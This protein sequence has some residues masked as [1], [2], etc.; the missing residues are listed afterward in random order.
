M[1]TKLGVANSWLCQRASAFLLAL[2]T[3]ITV[4]SPAFGQSVKTI[5]LEKA[6]L[7]LEKARNDYHMGQ[8][9]VERASLAKS[10]VDQLEIA[11]R[12]ALLDYQEKLVES[13]LLTSGIAV[14][15]AVRQE[16]AA[17]ERIVRLELYNSLS[18]EQYLVG[19]DTELV[20]IPLLAKGLRAVTVSLLRDNTI[21]GLPY[22]LVIDEWPPRQTKVLTFTMLED[23][24][25]VTIRLTYQ[26]VST[27]R[28]VRLQ[29]E[30]S[31]EA[32][33]LACTHPFQ[34]ADLG[35]VTSFGLTL[36]RP[37]TTQ[38]SYRLQVMGLPQT[39]GTE[40]VDPTS[41]AR[42][43]SLNFG[44]AVTSQQV[45]LLVTLPTRPDSVVAVG[46]PLK[47]AVRAVSDDF[48]TGKVPAGQVSLE[49]VPWDRSK[50]TLVAESYYY[51][52][53]PGESVPI[54]VTVVNEGSSALHNV[55]L[56]IDAP[57]HWS[58]TGTPIIVPDILPKQ[59]TSLTV[60]VLAPADVGLGDF[61]ARL[62]AKTKVRGKDVE[63][64]EKVVRLHVESGAQWLSVAVVAVLLLGVVA[65]L[66][67][68]GIRLSRR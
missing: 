37:T 66:V 55:E 41:S 52:L 35:S 44:S 4:M 1:L 22:E 23:I 32:I 60:G 67:Y 58:V 49:L 46:T 18:A 13:G 45:V 15:K 43:T 2:A 38:R 19:S 57:P 48:Q 50:V 61:E 16:S 5:E 20:A 3:C 54:A 42:L 40:F 28:T 11:Y 26:G 62:R 53:Q 64:D 34:E 31:Q 7:S 30:L 8:K 21:V 24:K 25:D 17:G 10:T 36:D 56:V 6:K 12:F 9:L 63:S 65:G 59:T 47:F 14:R 68:F 33:A 27:D 51:E 29:S 39:V